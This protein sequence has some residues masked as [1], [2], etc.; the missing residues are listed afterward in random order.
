MRPL[1][2]HGCCGGDPSMCI[3][4]L[5]NLCDWAGN[6]KTNICLLRILGGYVVDPIMNIH[7]RHHT[8]CVCVCGDYP[9]VNIHLLHTTLLLPKWAWPH[10]KQRGRGR[11]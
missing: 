10:Y 11:R 1:H 9:T 6:P 7:L 3:H 2:T 5:Q 4:L 8:W